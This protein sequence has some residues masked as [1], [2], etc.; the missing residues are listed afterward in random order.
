MYEKYIQKLNLK[1]DD[2]LLIGSNILMFGKELL[3]EGIKFDPNLFINE[4]QKFLEN[5]TLLFPAFD[6][7]FCNKGVYNYN[8]PPPKL[9]GALSK[10][11]FKRGDFKRTSHPVFSFLVWGKY[12][13]D[14]LKLQNVDAFSMDSP[15][16][17]LYKLRAKMLIIDVEYNHVFTYIHFVEFMEKAP[18]RY[19]KTF[20]GRYIKDNYE[21]VKECRLYVRDEKLGVE[22]NS[23]E[24]GRILEKKGIAEV[25]NPVGNLK[26]VLIDL[27][28]A[29]DVIAYQIKHNP[30]SIVK[31][32]NLSKEMQ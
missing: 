12:Q 14:F 23:N 22:N 4:L 6:Y 27:Y 2:T 30:L 19:N 26:W 28:K 8:A 17:L 10:T 7:D 16:G 9:M 18:Y 29:Y 21:Y 31:F 25:Y 3:K 24:L 1:N 11:A 32:N 15:F 5:G 20:K 13:D